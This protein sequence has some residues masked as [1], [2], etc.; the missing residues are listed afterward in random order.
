MKKKLNSLTIL[1]IVTLVMVVLMMFTLQRP[2]EVSEDYSILF[3]ELFEQ[4]NGVDT[5]KF[6]SS[7][8][9]FTLYKQDEDWFVKERWNYSADFNLVKRALI[10]IAEAKILERKTANVEHHILLG[11]EGVDDG[12]ESIQVTMLNGE[13]PVAGLILGAEREIANNMGPRQFYVRRSNEDSVWLAEGYL[14]INPLMLNWI[15]SDVTNID[16]AR[17]A[18]VN[19]IQPNGEMATI[20]NIGIKD[21][22]GVPPM[23][24][25]T[26][27]K[28][29]QLGYD[30]AGTLNQLRMEDVQPLSGF[31]RG[32]SEVVTAEFITFDGLKVITE[33]SFIDGF[34]YTTFKA[35]YDA[36]SV[37]A[38]PE[39]IQQ[40]DVLKTVEHV[41]QEANTMTEELKPW[42]YRFGGF[43][44]TNM[45]RAE[46]DIVTKSDKVIPMPADI[47]GGFGR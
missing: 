19:I 28:Y 42:V 15:K 21:K 45:M 46:A 13:Q 29:E 44:G 22:F 14:N 2:N 41:K 36:S 4:L 20:V 1:F 47:T 16:R 17:I 31:S 37:K 25:K 3:P 34:Y 30:I 38:A 32:D 26:I 11:V 39:D 7:Q 18:Q 40:L 9:E 5:I 23:L 6:K 33:T 27:F 43:V 24:E 12:G 8:D 35:E 10:D